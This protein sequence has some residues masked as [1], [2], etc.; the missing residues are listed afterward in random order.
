MSG[1]VNE[2]KRIRIRATTHLGVVLVHG[3]GA[4]RS[5]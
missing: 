1:G 2:G 5:V 4:D 3:A